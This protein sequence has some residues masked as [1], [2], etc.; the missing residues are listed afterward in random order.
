MKRQTE[1]PQTYCVCAL[2]GTMSLL[3]KKWVLFTV[4]AIGSH[5]AVR[6]TQ[7]TK[8]L[9]GVSPATLSWILHRLGQSGLVNRK[10]YPEIPP[11]VEY[12]LTESGK[13]L[14]KAIIPILLWAA[15]R[16]GYSR[17]LDDCDPGQLVEVGSVRPARECRPAGATAPSPALPPPTRKPLLGSSMSRS[18]VRRRI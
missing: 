13:E 18:H 9:K 15:R 2:N 5:G 7:L 6:F 17:M 10:S 14:Q 12:S 16:D 11:R 8:E 1:P 3:G 4:N